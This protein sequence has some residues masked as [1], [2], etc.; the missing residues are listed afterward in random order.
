MKLKSNI[1]NV[2]DLLST[3]MKESK[4]SYFTNYFQ[5]NPNDWKST[6]KDIKNLISQKKLPYVAPSNIFDNDRSLTEPELIATAFNKYLFLHY[7]RFFL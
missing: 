3:L 7:T 5:N 1:N 2:R 4:G 6:W